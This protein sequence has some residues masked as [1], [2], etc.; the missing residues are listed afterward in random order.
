MWHFVVGQYGASNIDLLFGL[1]VMLG[2]ME[3]V[4][5]WSCSRRQ[6]PMVPAILLAWDLDVYHEFWRCSSNDRSGGPSK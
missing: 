5:M 4:S 1:V 6:A 3:A 2:L